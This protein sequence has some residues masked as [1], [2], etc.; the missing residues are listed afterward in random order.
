MQHAVHHAIAAH[1]R[2]RRR[3]RAARLFR[4]GQI[5]LNRMNFFPTGFH[6]RRQFRQPIGTGD[7]VSAFPQDP[8]EM[9]DE[10]F[11]QLP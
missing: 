10:A 9:S 5:G 6:V 2:R 4:P 7:D 8:L 11:E 3:A 1:S